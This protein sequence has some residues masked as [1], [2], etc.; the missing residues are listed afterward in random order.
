[1]SMIIS[2][3]ELPAADVHQID[4]DNLAWTV[5]GT[6]VVVLWIPPREGQAAAI[7]LGIGPVVIPIDNEAVRPLALA[8][9]AAGSAPTS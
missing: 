6:P 7:G 4:G 5:D 9:L 1:M 3:D 8:L 2:S